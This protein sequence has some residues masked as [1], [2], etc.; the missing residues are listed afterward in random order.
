MLVM[1]FS[2]LY[3]FLQ[4]KGSFFPPS[5][6]PQF[7]LHYYLPEGSDIRATSNDLKVLEEHLLN[8]ERVVS[9][10]SFIGEGAPRFMLTFSPETTPTKS[11]GMIMVQVNDA[12]VIDD[13]VSGLTEYMTVQFPDAEPKIKRIMIGPPTKAQIETRFSGSDPVI[14]RELSEKAQYIFRTTAFT[15]SIRD[16]WRH[17][18]KEIR[19]QYSE[20]D[21]RNSGISKPD[22]NIALEMATT[23]TVVGMLREND[24][25]IPIISRYPESERADVNNLNNLQ[26]F[27]STTRQSVPIMQIISDIKTEWNDALVQKRDRKYTITISCEPVEGVLASEVFSQLKNKIESIKLPAGYEMEWGGEFESSRDAQASIGENLPLTFLAMMF[28]LILLFNSIRLPVIIFL[29]VPL[30]L[31]GV[32][33]GLLITGLPFSFMALLGFLSLVGMQI[34]NAIVL[35]DQINADREHGYKP[36]DA[37]VHASVSR[38]RPVTM[39]AITTVFGLIPLVT[40]AF[41]NGMAVT[42]MAGLSFA[43]ILTLI[44]IPVFYAI[45]F[46]VQK[47]NSS[48]R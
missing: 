27:S 22:F 32:S 19:P 37:I 34:K 20:T 41:F 5:T 1:L 39:A 28:I 14:L 6:R 15:T 24:K 2:A 33:A 23:G 44:V 40:D 16:N 31:I 12:S 30:T 36:Y 42:I 46:N 25:L 13:M 7:L 18:V 11:Y 45:A 38:M 43:T 48:M 29:T 9:T 4:I 10:S 3:G 21:A 17:K 47:P 26:I 8:D 35:I